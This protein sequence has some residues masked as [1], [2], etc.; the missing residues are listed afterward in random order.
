MRP[1]QDVETHAMRALAAA[2]ADAVIERLRSNPIVAPEWLS[3]QD[4][5]VYAGYSEQQFSEFVRTKRAPKSI[6]FSN[7]ARRFKRSDVDAWCVAGGPSQYNEDGSLV[8]GAV[9]P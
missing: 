2:A 3:L 7:N 8:S 6:K 1:N 5:A 9:K 4:A